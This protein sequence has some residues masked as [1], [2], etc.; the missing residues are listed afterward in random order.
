[1][2]ADLKAVPDTEMYGGGFEK[3]G[4]RVPHYLLY[5]PA[6]ELWLNTLDE[7]DVFNCSECSGQGEVEG[8]C[9]EC[10]STI[11]EQIERCDGDGTIH[12]PDEILK[13]DVLAETVWA[14]NVRDMLTKWAEAMGFD[15]AAV[16]GAAFISRQY[17]RD[18][19]YVK[20]HKVGGCWV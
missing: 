20:Q 11:M 13:E 2:G 4:I 15:P 5:E 18:G 17:K 19:E 14:C 6:A 9:C 8:E 7:D 3:N 12:D 10:G 1:M 16:L